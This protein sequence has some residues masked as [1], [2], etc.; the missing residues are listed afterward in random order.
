VIYNELLWQHKLR[1]FQKEMIRSV[2]ESRR[3]FM[4]G[5]RQIGKTFTLSYLA[6]LLAG[7][8]RSGSVTI[9][10]HDVL[11]IS[12]E[13]AKAQKVIRDVSHHL[14]RFAVEH[15]LR[16]TSLGSLQRIALAN[17]SH[18]M[19]TTGKP[20]SLQS[21][22][23]S[24]FVD[25][26]SITAHDPEEIVAQALS[27]S[28][29]AEHMRVLI[30][31]NADEPESFVHRFLEDDA[32]GSQ[33]AMYSVLSVSIHD[34]YPNG[35]P[36]HI[37]ELRDSMS[38]AMWAR[39]FENRFVSAG[40]MAF[41]EVLGSVQRPSGGWSAV[42]LGT[43]PELPAVDW[44]RPEGGGLRVM[45]VD[46]GW[47]S[48]PT[49]VVFATVHGAHVEVHGEVRL[50]GGSF[51]EQAKSL[52]ETFRSSGAF[53]LI[54]D[55]GRAEDL[56]GTLERTLGKNRVERLYCG[57]KAMDRWAT[58]LRTSAKEAT[59]PDACL[60]VWHGLRQAKRKLVNR[61]AVPGIIFPETRSRYARSDG[62]GK[63]VDHCD[64]AAAFLMCYSQI[65]ESRSTGQSRILDSLSW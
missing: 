61:R 7:G 64:A 46:V 3:T 20:T 11:I 47:T 6:V 33:R 57:D 8:C 56:A 37:A 14:D 43:M 51:E 41:E 22:T 65:V 31:T 19:A 29:S 23:G 28:S 38:P 13:L 53:R 36:S 52:C 42:G 58:T 16:D 24:V 25:E 40:E 17:G 12:S 27:V 39:F 35:L 4:I 50:Y 55:A 63:H 49:A 54:L 62:A 2:L 18:I 10:G 21:F 26:L 1:P 32:F 9:P 5:S 45:S 59:I 34:A 48:H 60:E 30:C 44:A 15:E